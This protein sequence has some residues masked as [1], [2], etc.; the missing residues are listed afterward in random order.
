MRRGKRIRWRDSRSTLPARRKRRRRRRRDTKRGGTYYPMEVEADVARSGV[1]SRLVGAVFAAMLTLASV[2][3]GI[4]APHSF[5]AIFGF[6][7]GLCSFGAAVGLLMSARHEEQVHALAA[8][9]DD[10]KLLDTDGDVSDSDRPMLV[11]DREQP[12]LPAPDQT[13]GAI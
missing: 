13:D 8:S 1:R 10:S 9:L 6:T 12:A 5:G 4:L 11:T 7:T 3:A 2:I